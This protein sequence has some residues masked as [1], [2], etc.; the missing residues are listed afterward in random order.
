MTEKQCSVKTLMDLQVFTH[1]Y[2]IAI[3]KATVRNMPLSSMK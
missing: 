2:C 3:P 1:K